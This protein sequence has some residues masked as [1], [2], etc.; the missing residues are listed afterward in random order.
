MESGKIR[1]LTSF[2]Q[3]VLVFLGA[4]LT[5]SLFEVWAFFPFWIK[6]IAFL[7]SL[8]MIY[9]LAR[10]KLKNAA[11]KLRSRKQHT[12]KESWV[13]HG[14]SALVLAG[15][16]VGLNHAGP[17][18]AG[19]MGQALTFSLKQPPKEIWLT[20]TVTPPDF[21]S[22]DPVTVFSPA[23]G[24]VGRRVNETPVTFPEG[25]IVEIEILNA[26]D[27][28]PFVALGNGLDQP[29]FEGD[30]IFISKHLLQ[31]DSPLEIQVGPYVAY[32][33]FFQ[34]IPDD[35]PSVEIFGDITVSPRNSLEISFRA[36]DDNGIEEVYLE[37][38]QRGLIT[39]ENDRVR[40]PYLMG[41]NEEES[42]THYVN[43]LSHPWAG[44]SVIGAITVVDGLGQE[45]TSE[46]LLVLLPEK[47]F[48]NPL[49]QRLISIRKALIFNPEQQDTQVRRLDTL[50]KNGTAFEENKGIYLALRLA[51]W[52]LRSAETNA[53]LDEVGR[54]LWQAALA[55]E[56]DGSLEEQQIFDTLD[57]MTAVLSTPE[58][59]EDF[60][61]LSRSLKSRIENF[62]DREF[63]LSPRRQSLQGNIRR[64]D[65]PAFHTIRG[66][67]TEMQE[68]AQKGQTDK[69]MGTLVK[70]KGLFEELAVS[71]YSQAE[72]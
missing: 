39:L 48:R 40:V 22:T 56:D 61:N 71:T 66:L 18:A 43:L 64:M 68:E 27:Y 11:I 7:V 29:A 44:A 33:Q 69:A 53:D 58:K 23:H 2:L 41:L 35:S 42:T 50:T 15:F 12:Y 13:L 62:F 10:V 51:Y 47:M 9:K 52:R 34:A 70:F 21:L 49:S 60:Q 26:G 72:N 32:R 25:S 20:I 24:P 1:L 46:E 5:L 63:Q 55:L 36:K 16:V 57:R 3:L 30:N 8:G 45:T 67:I 38:R 28:S 54:F 59:L 14:L 19:R 65:I 4:Y 37:L 31:E 6:N 17:G